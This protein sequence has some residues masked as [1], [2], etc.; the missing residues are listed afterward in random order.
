V[1]SLRN[2]AGAFVTPTLASITAAI[3]ASAPALAQ[4]VRA[5]I[6]DAPGAGAYPISALTF[7]LVNQD[8]PDARKA[9]AL[10]DFIAWAIHDGQAMAE[11]LDYAPL[12]QALVHVD[13][14]LLRRLTGAGRP[15]AARTE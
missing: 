14:T 1:A 4:D 5:P 3:D 15:I 12:P 2:R 6:V 8:M 11:P 9:A 13:E 7:L 10:R